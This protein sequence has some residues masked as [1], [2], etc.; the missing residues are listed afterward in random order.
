MDECS[1][2][3]ARIG[4]LRIALLLAASTVLPAINGWRWLAERCR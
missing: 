2:I 4:I 1:R 3:P